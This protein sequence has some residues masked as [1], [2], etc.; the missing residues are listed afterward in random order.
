VATVKAMATLGACALLAGCF[1]RSYGA[2]LAMHTDLLLAMTRKGADLVEARRFAPENLP[3][4]HYPLERARAFAARAHRESGADPPASLEV[5]DALL[6]AYEG[7]CQVAD[8]L[9]RPGR[10]GPGDP[11][12]RQG[13]A[14]V[15]LAGEHVRQ[16]LVAEG[17]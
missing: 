3:E 6:V 5:F 7:F 8:D 17:R 11:T 15:Q 10:W 12:L 14:N 9:R 4:L 16:A 1:W 13:V 2:R